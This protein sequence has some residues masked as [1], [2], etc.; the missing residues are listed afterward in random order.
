MRGFRK[1]AFLIILPLSLF[2]FAFEEKDSFEIVKNLDI[3]ITALREVQANY[4]DPV[5]VKQIVF[6]GIDK[7]LDGLD[8]YTEFVPE[9]QVDNFKMTHVSTHYGGIGALIQEN[10]G[11]LVIAEPYENFP[12]QKGGL[13]AGDILVKVN[14]V[15]VKGK[16]AE[17]VSD[18]LR[19]FK[20]TLVKISYRKP[21]DQNTQTIQLTREEIKVNNVSYSGTVAPGIGYIRLDKFLENSGIEVREAF[22]K[23]KEKEKITSLILDLRGNGGGIMMDAVKMAN[24]FLPEGKLIVSQKGKV[25]DYNEAFY[26]TTAPLDREIPIAILIDG[27]S[28]SAS[29]IVAGAIQDHDRGVVIGQRTFGKGLVQNTVNLPYN[30]L[31]KITISKYYTPSGRCIQAL[32][33]AK[34]NSFGNVVRVP[35]S[36]I[37]E[38]KTSNGRKVYDGSGIYPDIPVEL[39][40]YQVVT[41]ALFSKNMFF[42]FANRYA[43]K[44]ATIAPAKTFTLSDREYEEFVAFCTDKKFSYES[45]TDTK[46]KELSGKGDKYGAEYNEALEKIK[47]DLARFRSDE[48]RRHRSQI[49]NLL[50][51]EIAARYHYQHGRLES[52]FRFDEA[53]RKAVDVL[54][55]R[56][57]Y[58]RILKGEGQYGTIGKPGTTGSEEFTALET[59]QNAPR[60][61]PAEDHE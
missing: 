37:T 36:L 45:E 12:A 27:G 35:D 32:D 29:E 3:M 34:K 58:H 5:P 24:F 31:V 54:N 10:D 18:L 59:E 44:N 22:L 47:S 46:L 21:G 56:E 11:E 43:A 1:L 60:N 51:S 23:L 6:K 48:L 40:K 57:L 15:E 61:V 25:E 19:G 55:D 8:P 7:M 38:F 53:L 52:S 41:S 16:N 20:G 39:S 14:D 4:V 2:L 30:A 9:E 50:E 17:E 49:Q 33:Y 26:S 28:A 13:R 42:N